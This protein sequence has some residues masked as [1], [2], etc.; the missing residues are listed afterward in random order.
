MNHGFRTARTAAL[1]LAL[2]A[3]ALN[4]SAPAAA[5]AADPLGE[6]LARVPASPASHSTQSGPSPAQRLQVQNTLARLPLAFEPNRG[7]APQ[8]VQFLTRAPGYLLQLSATEARL[9]VRGEWPKE[10]RQSHGT[11]QGSNDTPR[12]AP[13][14][15]RLRWLGADSEAPATAEAELPGTVNYLKGSDPANW[16]TAIPTYEKV[17]YQDLY[18]GIDLLYY[19]EPLKIRFFTP[20]TEQHALRPSPLRG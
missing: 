12:Y 16:H 1:A 19:R 8:G 3:V 11:A 10:L 15:L 13:Q 5:A 4:N 14:E 18:P 2:G 6:R 9:L 17:R 20:H 7:Q